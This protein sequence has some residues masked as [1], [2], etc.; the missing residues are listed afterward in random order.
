MFILTIFYAYSVN[1]LQPGD[2]E[3]VAA[4]GESEEVTEDDTDDGAGDSVI[5]ATGAKAPNIFHSREQYRGVSFAIGGAE[6]W[7]T[8]STIPNFLR[9]FNPYLVGGSVNIGGEFDKG[10]N[11]NLAR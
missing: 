6:T 4:L 5:G 2:I 10:S 3:I 9:V 1:K 8:V 11:L 7:H